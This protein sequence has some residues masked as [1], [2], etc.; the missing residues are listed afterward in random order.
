M[1]KMSVTFITFKTAQTLILQYKMRLL[2][3]LFRHADY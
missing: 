2:C 1:P 3:R